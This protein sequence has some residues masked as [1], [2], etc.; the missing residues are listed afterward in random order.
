M[1]VVQINSVCGSG[2]TGKIA[3][4]ISKS[5]TEQGIENYILYGI[6]KSDYPLGICVSNM[7]YVK[8][9]ILMTRIFGKHGFYSHIATWKII[10]HLK[11]I[12]P[13]IIHLHNIHGH[14]LNVKMLFKYIKK[15]NIKTIWTLHDCWSFTGHCSHF[16]YIGCEKWKNGCHNC[17]QLREYPVSLVFDRSRGAYKAK[18]NAFLGVNDLTIVT[19]S[20]WLGEMV[21][22]S[23]LKN[24]PHMTL[25]NGIDLSLFK[26]CKSDIKEK[27]GVVNKKV[28]LAVSAHFGERKGYEY[29]LELAKRL[30]K[31]Y[32]MIMVGVTNEQKKT[33]PENVI[34]ITRTENQEELVKI[35]AAADVMVN[36]TLEDTFPTVNIESLA[37]GTPVVTWQ[38]GG[39]PEIV[40]EECGVVTKAL[41]IDAIYEAILRVANENHTDKCKK[42]AEDKYSKRKMIEEYMELYGVKGIEK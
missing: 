23:F 22:Q 24:Y 42:R 25:N 18:K 31:E 1:K 21:S 5:L 40:S 7:L 16:N 28:I 8:L 39:S 34:G 32:A 10:C 14:Y 30:P 17:E 4:D 36:L 9:N 37:C 33:L 12:N 13:D 38:V 35:Y 41:D 26:P 3:I 6:G 19:P 20:D 15:H 2:S 11:R 29:Y 27:L